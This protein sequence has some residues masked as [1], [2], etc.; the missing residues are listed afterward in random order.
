MTRFSL[1]FIA[2]AACVPPSSSTGTGMG[3]GPA[4]STASQG[5][6]CDAACARLAACEIVTDT[7]ACIQECHVGGYT[8]DTLSQL[9]HGECGE[10]N[11]WMAQ[12]RAAQGGGGGDQAGYDTSGGDSGG[13]GYSGGGRSS[14][15]AGE[16]SS[17]T[18][19]DG[20]CGGLTVCCGSNGPAAHGTPGVCHSVSICNMPKR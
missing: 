12:S 9:E 20:R 14:L 15:T 5:G 7:N 17:C 16:G 18:G 8:P 13:G 3:T 4:S 2:I 11:E 6:T 19:G 10:I 1:V